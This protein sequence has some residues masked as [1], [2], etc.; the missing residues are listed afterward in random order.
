[1]II[2]QKIFYFSRLCCTLQSSMFLFSKFF[3]YFY[4]VIKETILRWKRKVMLNRHY[5]NHTYI[6]VGKRCTGGHKVKQYLGPYWMFKR[7]IGNE[8]WCGNE[9]QMSCLSIRARAT[10]TRIITQQPHGIEK[11]KTM[12]KIIHILHS[13]E[14]RYREY[15]KE[16][17]NMSCISP[18]V[19]TRKNNPP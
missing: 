13:Y 2:W 15:H 12:C 4:F 6:Y 11:T 10:G 7:Q 14:C 1:M 16:S 17:L 19:A 8:R 9:R 3:E 5:N 18:D